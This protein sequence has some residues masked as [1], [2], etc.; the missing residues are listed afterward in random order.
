MKKIAFI[1][2]ASLVIMACG[3]NVADSVVSKAVSKQA[4]ILS[5][6]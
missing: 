5:S 2:L 4:A 6:I 3:H 1:V